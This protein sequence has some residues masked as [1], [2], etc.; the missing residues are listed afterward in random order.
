VIYGVGTRGCV[1]RHRLVIQRAGGSG[2]SG[3]ESSRETIRVELERARRQFHEFLDAST[4][5]RLAGPS[6][7][8]RWTTGQLLFH[9]LFG[10][11]TTRNLR[12]VV[13]IVTRLPL[14]VQ[15]GFAGLIDTATRPLHRINYWGSCWVYRLVAAGRMGRWC[16]RVIGCLQHH[17]ATDSDD[18]LARSMAFPVRWDPYFTT[19]M[20]LVGVY[21]YATLHF[22]HHRRRL[23]ILDTG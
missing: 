6:N 2:S 17:L 4:P 13:M 8:T 10:Y 23:T 15:R 20:S 18:A 22:D 7:G 14:R 12:V 1:G 16:D 3:T 5:E 9:M 19:R 21:H 11:L